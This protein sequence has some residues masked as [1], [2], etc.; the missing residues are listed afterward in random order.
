MHAACRTAEDQALYQ[1]CRVCD[2]DRRQEVIAIVM[3][4]R[5]HLANMARTAA[6]A[7]RAERAVNLAVWF[8]TGHATRHALDAAKLHIRDIIVLRVQM[9]VPLESRAN[10]ISNLKEAYS[11]D[12]PHNTL[13]RLLHAHSKALAPLFPHCFSSINQRNRRAR[14]RRDRGTQSA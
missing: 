14:P 6:L 5:L 2:A 8:T 4:A 11:G 3:R 7:V 12:L 9:G 10:F 1:L 13:C